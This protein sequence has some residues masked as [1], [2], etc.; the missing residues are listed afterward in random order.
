MDQIRFNIDLTRAGRSRSGLVYAGVSLTLDSVAFPHDDWTDFVVVILS[1]W[2][3][4]AVQLLRSP[5][6]LRIDVRFME[7]PYLVAVR[8]LGPDVWHV[9]LVESGQ[10]R[11]ELR[12]AEVSSAPFVQSILDASTRVLDMCRQ[13]EWWSSDADAL[14]EGTAALEAACDSTSRNA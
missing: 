12:S 6:P 7:G 14:V 4:A 9:A 8:A 3:N 5:S 1:W 2:T 10:R 13:R 11:R